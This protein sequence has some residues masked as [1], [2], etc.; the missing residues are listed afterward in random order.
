[1]KHGKIH[2]RIGFLTISLSLALAC[3]AAYAVTKFEQLNTQAENFY[4]TRNYAEAQKCFEQALKEGEKLEASDKRV[5]TTYYNLALCFQAQGSYADA[6]KNM[7]KSLELMKFVYGAEHQRVAQVFMDLADLYLEQAGQENK[8]E[9]KARAAENY[10]KGIEIFEKIYTQSTGQEEG[11]E[12]PKTKKAAGARVEP[13]ETAADLSNALRLLADF[14]AQEEQF[15]QAD[16]LYKRSLELEEFA[17]GPESKDLA[18]HKARVAEFYCVQAKY[19]PAEPLFK[20]ALAIYDKVDPN[21]V[22]TANLLYNY[23]GFFYDQGLY[24][25][26]EV[27]FKRAIKIFEKDPDQN[28]QDIAQKN[29]ALGDVLDMQGKSEEAHAIYKKSIAALEKQEDKAPLIQCL[30]QYQKHLLMQNNKDEAGKVAIRIKD[31]RASQKKA[32]QETK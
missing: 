6:E 15:D 12:A 26:A 29:I 10:K 19:K 7:V 9:L 24:G 3:P 17:E 21:S 1:M 13:Q 5:A 28:D 18:K 16:P 8:P 27:M 11:G 25:D 32:Q 20:D 22:E 14:Y 31:L 23:G 30:K 4:K 2:S